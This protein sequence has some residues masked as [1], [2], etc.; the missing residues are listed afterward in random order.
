MLCETV[1][2]HTLATQYARPRPQKLEC[3]GAMHL[4]HHSARSRVELSQ[5]KFIWSK[6]QLRRSGQAEGD[7]RGTG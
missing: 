3:V 4:M 6:A 5:C 1:E 2:A 7:E